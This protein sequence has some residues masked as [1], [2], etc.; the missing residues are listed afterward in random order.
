MNRNKCR[1]TP[2]CRFAFGTS[3]P[4]TE[5][6]GSVPG[7]S[8][9]GQGSISRLDGRDSCGRVGSTEALEVYAARGQ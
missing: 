3:A 9:T 6:R 2:R 4:G 5:Y 1:L 8:T 7:S